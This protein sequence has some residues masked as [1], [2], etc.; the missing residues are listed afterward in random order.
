MKTRLICNLVKGL[1]VTFVFV[2]F[3]S[4]TSNQAN[5]V[6]VSNTNGVTPEIPLMGSLDRGQLRAIKQIAANVTTTEDNFVIE[7]NAGK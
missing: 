3:S 4:F 1:L 2:L 6:N 5:L 7:D